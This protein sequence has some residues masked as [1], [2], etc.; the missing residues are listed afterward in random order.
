LISLITWCIIWVTRKPLRGVFHVKQRADEIT[1]AVTA[2]ARKLSVNIPAD[3]L[4]SVI[5]A[6]S[7]LAP[8]AHRLG[9]TKYSD[10]ETIVKQLVLPALC[11]LSPEFRPFLQSPVLEFGSGSGAIGISLAILAPEEQFVLAD[12]RRRVVEF[13]DVAIRRHGL[14]NCQALLVDLSAPTDEHQASFGTVLLRAYGPAEEALTQAARWLWLGGHVAF[15]HQ[16]PAPLAPDGL[17]RTRS[18]QTNLSALLLT[19]YTKQ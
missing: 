12:R 8:S 17:I 4:Q 6:I 1:P 16:P 7:W 18:E 19:A 3:R 13:L 5:S 10:P 9:L 11:L 14:A 15:W 2:A